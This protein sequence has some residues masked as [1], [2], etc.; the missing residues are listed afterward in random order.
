MGMSISPTTLGICARRRDEVFN[1]FREFKALV[2]NQTR[3]KIKVLRSYN[4]GEY[5]S[6]NFRNLCKETSIKR[7][8]KVPF[9]PQQNG[10]AERK[11]RTIV[12]ATKAM[13]HDQDLPMLLWE[14]HVT[15]QSMFRTRVLIRYW[16]TRPLRRHSQE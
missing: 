1:Q 12:E 10:V 4:G 15:W 6:N 7:K 2:E 9:N 13:L 16:R 5:T 14:R 11:N 3:T 8:L